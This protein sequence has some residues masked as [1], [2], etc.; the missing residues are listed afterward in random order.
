MYAI[1]LAP[2]FNR[3]PNIILDGSYFSLFK[4]PIC[5]KDQLSSVKPA[6]NVY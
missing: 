1:C 2:M 6:E 4:L 3:L 5:M